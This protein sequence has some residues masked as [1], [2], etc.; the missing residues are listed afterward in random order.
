MKRNHLIASSLTAAAVCALTGW[1]ISAEP[2]PKLAKQKAEMMATMRQKLAYSQGVT[3][4]LT[5]GKLD[6]V[7]ENAVKLRDMTQSNIWT[8][9]DNPD[10]KRLTKEYVEN[11]DSVYMAAV[12]S[13]LDATTEAY[14]KSLK[15][16]VECHR[17]L[18]AGTVGSRKK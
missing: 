8:W 7:K 1:V 5:L 11:V 18:R 16:C 4:G 15:S 10:Y 3:E 6:L 12:D 9:V 14:A 2:T 17:T 13:D